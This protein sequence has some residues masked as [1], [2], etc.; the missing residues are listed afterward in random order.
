[1]GP[2][3]AVWTRAKNFGEVLS[4]FTESRIGLYEGVIYVLS[5]N[6]CTQNLNCEQEVV[7]RMTSEYLD[8]KPH[9]ELMHCENPPN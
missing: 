9:A 6:T 7:M 8:H 3:L 2:C 4:V 5:V 1:M